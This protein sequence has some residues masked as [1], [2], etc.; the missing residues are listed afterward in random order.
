MANYKL[1]VLVISLIMKNENVDFFTAL[2][3]FI[4]TETYKLVEDNTLLTEAPIAIYDMYKTER[5]CGTYLK[6]KYVEDLI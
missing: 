4:N 1:K 3:Q 6:S 5:E 2:T